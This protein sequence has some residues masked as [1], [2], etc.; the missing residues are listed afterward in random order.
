MYKKICAVFVMLSLIWTLQV[1]AIS[2]TT[3]QEERDYISLLSA[4][5]YVFNDWQTD[6]QRGYNIGCV[7]LIGPKETDNLVWADKNCVNGELR[8]G[9]QHGE[10]RCMQNYIIW[11]VKNH[12]GRTDKPDLSKA[13]IYTT[14]EPCAQCSGMMTMQRIHSTIYGQTD[15]NFGKVLERLSLDSTSINGYK[16]YPWTVESTRS[17]C[18]YTTALEMA[19]TLWLRE[20]PNG[21]ITKFLTTLAAQQIFLKA[22]KEFEKFPVQFDSNKDFYAKAKDL[23]DK[24]YIPPTDMVPGVSE[25]AYAY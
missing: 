21:A 15:P 3:W 8:N 20:N 24:G 4:Y 9:T 10:I 16:P 13:T 7:M 11:W 19:Y 25:E 5:T 12:P 14:L 2:F 22:K 17:K 18:E 1:H 6:N 23:V